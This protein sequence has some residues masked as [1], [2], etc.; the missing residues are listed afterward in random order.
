MNDRAL[1]AASVLMRMAAALLVLVV[2]ARG[3]GPSLFGLVAT[4]F[5]YAT[6]LSLITDFGFSSKLLRDVAMDPD[7]GGTVL[8]AALNVKFYLSIVAILICVGLTLFL[9]L[10]WA[11]RL[12]VLMLTVGI[13]V[14]A[15]GDLS[16]V[17]LRATGRYGVEASVTLGTSLAHVV[18]VGVAATIGGGVL[19]VSCAFLASRIL[20][21]GA[22][23]VAIRRSFPQAVF[24]R[25]RW[26]TV[27]SSLLQSKSWAVDAGMGYINGQFDGLVV[28]AAFGLPAAGIY[29]AGGRFVQAG[30]SLSAVLS[31]IHIPRLSRSNTVGMKWRAFSEFGLAGLGLGSCLAILGPLLTKYILGPQYAKVD[32]LWLGFGVFLAARY[33]AA[34]L[35][36]ILTAERRMATRIGG[37]VSALGIATLFIVVPWPGRQY[38]VMP[39]L[40][41]VCALV[42][43]AIYCAPLILR[44]NEEGRVR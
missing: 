44:W 31:G 32:Q 24:S 28:A 42:T 38:T 15:L 36:A 30:L 20:Y 17:A 3:L 11:E 23:A 37:Q 7:D 9:P 12:S 25:Q 33:V 22:A 43:C 8:N 5:T 18:V 34:G 21:C 10:S 35:G 2:M 41:A 40:M 39:W 26:K 13:L 27:R 14:A 19:T 29:Q 6:L 4:V 16:F 1:M